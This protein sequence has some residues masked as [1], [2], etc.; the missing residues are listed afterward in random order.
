MNLLSIYNNVS[1]TIKICFSIIETHWIPLERGI[2]V[3]S[4]RYSI[5]DITCFSNRARE[6]VFKNKIP[7][8]RSFSFFW[9]HIA[10][11]N[12]F[13]RINSL[14]RI[15]PSC[16]DLYHPTAI[17]FP[18]ILFCRLAF[19]SFLF[20][21]FFMLFFFFLL[22]P[23]NF[24]RLYGSRLSNRARYVSSTDRPDRDC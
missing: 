1:W 21:L 7:G 3:A 10:R 13:R 6:Y 22:F 12:I 16:T 15:C 5:T 19:L 14:W 9:L 17:L 2:S 11:F 8:F 23:D 24:E 20:S 18:K 4:S